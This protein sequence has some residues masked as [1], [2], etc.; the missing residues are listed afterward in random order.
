[1]LEKIVVFI[2]VIIALFVLIR[3]IYLGISEKSVSC[4]CSGCPYDPSCKLK[5]VDGDCGLKNKDRLGEVHQ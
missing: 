3:R 4:G 1:M 2:I 5:D